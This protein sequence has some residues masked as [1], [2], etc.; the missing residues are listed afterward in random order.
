MRIAYGVHGYGHGHATRACA[1]LP[2]LLRRHDVRI[3]AGG[4][5]FETL[6]DAFD[7]RQIPTLAFAYR[8]GRRSTW[9]TLKR[10]LP[11]MNDIVGVGDTTRSVLDE[12]R[13]FAPHVV[14]CDCEPWTFRAACL[15]SIPRIA[16]DHFGIMV[17]C[18]VPLPW[19]DW[20]KSLVDR[21]VYQLMVGRASRALVSS[22]YSAP[23]RSPG[24]RLIGPLLRGQ[25]RSVAPS[26]GS[27]LLAYFNQGAI[28]LTDSILQALTGAGPEVRLYGARRQGRFGNVIFRPRA[29][30]PFL[31]DLASCRAVISTAGNQLVGEA[32]QFG[33][34]LLV[35]PE[36]SVEQRMNAAAIARLSLGE[37]ID[38]DELT[39]GVIR[40]F[41]E[42]AP[43]YAENALRQARDGGQEAIETLEKWI[44]ELSPRE[45]RGERYREAMA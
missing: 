23:A 41:L 21:S 32:M 2:D 35:M 16:F 12:L 14:V 11:L 10:N 15:L 34:P 29:D 4:D 36:A 19:L 45:V 17:R 42:R 27:H 24:V 25:A 22:F 1:V 31:E 39:P 5:A 30:R 44:A 13:R 43:A 28:Q 20:L 7:V 40:R 3:F 8:N 9:L 38:T 33:K 18:K 26:E 6:S 37:S